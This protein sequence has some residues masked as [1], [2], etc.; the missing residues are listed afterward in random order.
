MS[1]L[2]IMIL[3]FF[4]FLGLL[5]QHMGVPRLGVE[6]DLQLLA[7]TTVIAM[8]DPSR[9]CDLHHSTQQRWIL[10]PLSKAR[11]RTRVLV[12][13]GQVCKLLSHSGNST[14][15][16]LLAWFSDLSGISSC[17]RFL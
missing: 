2:T 7:H 4:P 3:F 15:A 5:P 9:V 11:D 12:D 1:K 13:A 10:N 14:S 16:L 8:Q 6:S 17:P